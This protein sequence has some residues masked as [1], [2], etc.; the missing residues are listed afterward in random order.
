MEQTSGFD[1]SHDGFQASVAPE[2]LRDIPMFSPLDDASLAELSK[3]LVTENVPEQRAVI[4]QGDLDSYV[5]VRGCVE[6][7]HENRARR[8]SRCRRLSRTATASARRLCSI[9]SSEPLRFAP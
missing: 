1:V 4:H 7:L 6:V 5:V 3:H 2:R 8:R 9:G